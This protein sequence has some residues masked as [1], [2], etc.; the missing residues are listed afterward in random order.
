MLI[1]NLIET[2]PDLGSGGIL[3]TKLDN[4]GGK[5]KT[6]FKGILGLNA[7]GT[8][9]KEKCTFKAGLKEFP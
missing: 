8:T 1:Y 2:T 3:S 7:S 5:W 9:V 6:E 4:S